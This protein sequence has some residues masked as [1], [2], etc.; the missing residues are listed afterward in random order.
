ML[1]R[2]RPHAFQDLHSLAKQR[3][4]DSSVLETMSAC[5]YINISSQYNGSD[6]PRN[7]KTIPEGSESGPRT[8]ETTPHTPA[9][10]YGQLESQGSYPEAGSAAD[11]KKSTSLMNKFRPA[12]MRAKSRDLG[13][14]NGA[15]L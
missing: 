11:L 10:P 2:T 7:P 6:T 12:S 9:S 4:G 8:P 5:R 3:M 14:K 15:D 1:G 13:E